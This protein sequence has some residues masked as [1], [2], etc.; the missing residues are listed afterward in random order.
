MLAMDGKKEKSPWNGDVIHT[1]DRLYVVFYFTHVKCLLSHDVFLL[2]KLTPPNM[3]WGVTG[4]FCPNI[5]YDLF[6]V[7][8]DDNC[9]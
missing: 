1:V 4:S 8:K 9:Y 3:K 2:R 7:C 5:A 6:L